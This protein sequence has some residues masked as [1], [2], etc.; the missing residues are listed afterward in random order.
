MGVLGTNVA[1]AGEV[2]GSGKSLKNEDG[3]LQGKSICAFSG[4][5]D[6]YI[7]GEPLPDEDGFT[8]TQSWGQVSKEDKIVLTASGVS[9]GNSCNPT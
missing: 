7:A 4:L 8:R 5:N 2:T 6:N 1:F 9:P 3:S